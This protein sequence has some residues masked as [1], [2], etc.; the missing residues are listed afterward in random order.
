VTEAGF[1]DD[2]SVSHLNIYD[3]T[4]SDRK[5]YFA[6]EDTFGRSNHDFTDLVTSVEGV[7][8]SGAGEPCETG[9]MGACNAG[10][11]HCDGGAIRCMPVV[12]AEPEVCNGVNDDCNG[13]TDDGATCGDREVCDN[14]RCVPHCR[15]ADEFVCAAGFECNADDGICVE[16]ACRGVTCTG[17]GQVCRAGVCAAECE[18]VVCPHGQECF[19]DRCIDPC[20]SV[21]CGTGEVCRGGLCVPGCGRCDGVACE[22]GLTCATPGGECTD[23]S[24]PSGCA[25]G[26]FCRSGTCVDACEGAICPRGAL[27]AMGEC[28]VPE[29]EDAGPSTGFDSGPSS[30]MDAG[31]SMRSS[32]SSCGCRVQRARAAE[33]ALWLALGLVGL[34]LSRRRAQR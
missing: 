26:T 1:S 31:R 19:R 27:C 29:G 20:A 2:G 10:I 23:P 15:F 25:P 21:T 34:A 12:T 32:P 3:S 16:T 5:F 7:E 30:G 33:P 6:W 28:V 14:G 13:E 9:S 8:C 24:C 4:I 11:T 17:A 22:G 18:G